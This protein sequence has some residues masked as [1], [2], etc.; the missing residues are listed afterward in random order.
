MN[1]D[2]KFIQEAYNEVLESSDFVAK[3]K[4]NYGHLNPKFGT[5]DQGENKGKMFAIMPTKYS[6]GDRWYYDT[7][8]IYDGGGQSEGYSDEEVKRLYSLTEKN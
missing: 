4:R 6:D 3:V 2:Q 8:V 5:E 7:M 1:K